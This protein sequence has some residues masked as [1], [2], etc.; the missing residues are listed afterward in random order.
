MKGDS[1]EQKLQKKKNPKVSN[2]YISLCL[3]CKIPRR[4]LRGCP[5][6]NV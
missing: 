2:I 5:R 3:A 4:I 1:G 6:K